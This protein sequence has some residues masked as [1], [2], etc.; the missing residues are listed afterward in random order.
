LKKIVFISHDASRTGA[1]IL[2]L[3]LIKLIK[4]NTN[5]EISVILKNPGVL[6]NEFK[7]L[8]KTYIWYNENISNYKEIL[9]TRFFINYLNKRREIKR[10]LLIRKKVNSADVII[11]N[12][13]T[14]GEL[15]A[16]LVKDFK[17]E[18]ITY[19]H[20]LKLGFQ[21]F[22]TPLGI[23]QTINLS[24][25]IAVPSNAVRQNLLNSFNCSTDK[26]DF[27]NYYIPPVLMSQSPLI[28][29]KG[30]KEVLVIGGCGTLDWR[31]GID[32]FIMAAISLKYLGYGQ[33][34]KFIWKG[35]L[36]NS[37]QYEECIYDIR[38]AHIEDRFE[39][40]NADNNVADFYKE[41]DLLFLSSRE[42]PFP[43]SVLEAA[44]F[45]KPVIC[46]KD[47]GGATE[48]IQ[49]D[50]GSVVS[51]MN[52]S[53]IVEELLEYHNNQSLIEEKGEI[54]FKRLKKLHHDEKLILKQFINL[55]GTKG[56]CH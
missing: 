32:I 3:N 53:E 47:A 29:T 6:E 16:F 52:I 26:I 8:V 56:K 43:L 2:L 24:H 1:P 12:T 36:K 21:R 4:S 50:A 44:S 11:N 41:I 49:M 18:I 54:G 35:A 10:R 31:K 30:K 22:A 55:I 38:K 51:Y 37:I 39:F 7:N 17:G 46:F 23:S 27:L 45:S 40:L 20:E 48:F 25:K 9:Y 28:Q 33:L 13:I 34:F 5:F 14:N 42:D 19:V 15:L